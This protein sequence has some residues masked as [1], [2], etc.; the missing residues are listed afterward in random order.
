MVGLS[1]AVAGLL[2]GDFFG[3]SMLCG[4]GWAHRTGDPW[5]TGAA[6]DASLREKEQNNPSKPHPSFI[7]KLFPKRGYN[8]NSV[9][10]HSNK[11]KL[12]HFQIKYT[13]K[14]R[15]CNNYNCLVKW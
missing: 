1:A 14:K 12:A 15:R 11:Q 10:F 9:E 7:S 4:R 3:L 6:G 13:Q 5:L 2:C 8:K